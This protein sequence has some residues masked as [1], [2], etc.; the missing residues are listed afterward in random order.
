MAMSRLALAAFAALGLAGCPDAP[1]YDDFPGLAPPTGSSGGE[2]GSSTELIPTTMT[3]GDDTDE[4]GTTSPQSTSSGA[5]TTTTTPVDEQPTISLTLTPAEVMVAGPVELMIEASADVVGVDVVY[6]G[7]VIALDVPPAEFPLT[8]EVTSQAKCNG[9]EPI[10]VIAHDAASQMG[11]DSQ[12]LTC[13]LPASGS[14]ADQDVLPGTTMSMVHAVAVHGDGFVVVGVRDGRMVV[15]RVGFDLEVLPD[16]PLTLADWTAKEDIAQLESAA[17]AVT[18][19]AKQNIIVAGNTVEAGVKT[20]YVVKLNADGERMAEAQGE[21]EEE[22]AG[23]AVTADGVIV[24][25]GAVR[26]SK[27]PDAFDWRVWGHA[28]PGE[29]KPWVDTLPLG[30]GEKQD[31]GNIRSERARAIAALPDGDL[32]VV[33]ERDLQK[34]GESVP[35]SRASW[36]RYTATGERVGDLWTSG[37]EASFLD[38]ANAIVLLPGGFALTGWARDEMGK[39]ARVWSRH[40]ED[41]VA[42]HFR[43][44]PL[45]TAE[46]KGV[47]SDRE[48]KLVVAALRTEDKQL[49]AWAF[50]FADWAQVPEWSQLLFDPEGFDGYNGI[51]CTDWGHCL[52]GG[53]RTEAGKI[54]GF[55]RLH[56]P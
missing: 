37:G 10:K 48:G 7:D 16:W 40:F 14:T 11:Q 38:A 27:A 29:Q 33:G 25:A 35:Q 19:D 42:T 18:V 46:G 44:E 30:P 5:E 56:N 23:V 55:I 51:A 31:L 21:A 26:T 4:P 50:A 15:W 36:Q 3:P 47:A 28:K 24:V 8:F 13:M 41:G 17:V 32:V 9:A 54:T 49:D 53:F 39:S 20:Y 45:V 52:A 22:A 6:R 1:T 34:I 2:S 12:V 43:V